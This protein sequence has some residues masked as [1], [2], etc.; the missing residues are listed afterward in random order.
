M[1]C[2]GGNV[3]VGQKDERGAARRAF[4]AMVAELGTVAIGMLRVEFL[5]GWQ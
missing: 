1:A 5:G 4:F 2:L 3:Q